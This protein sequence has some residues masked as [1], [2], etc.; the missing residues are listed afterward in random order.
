MDALYT[1][2]V[3]LEGIDLNFPG[4][5]PPSRDAFDRVAGGREFDAFELSASEY[6]CRYATDDRQFIV[7]LVFPLRAFRRGFIAV[8][9]RTVKEPKDLNGKEVGVQ[10]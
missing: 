9:D 6:I 10:L 5:S 7:L 2:E 8:N 4:H 3:K 1:G